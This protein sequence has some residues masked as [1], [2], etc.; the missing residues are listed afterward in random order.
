MLPHNADYAS[1]DNNS[2]CVHVSPHDESHN[3]ESEWEKK[4][5]KCGR[6]TTLDQGWTHVSTTGM[7]L[8]MKATAI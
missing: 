1:K 4:K 2:L 7:M 5:N 3:E 6:I 8:A